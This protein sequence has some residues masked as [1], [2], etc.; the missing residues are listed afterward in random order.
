[1]VT[2]SFALCYVSFNHMRRI[3]YYKKYNML[4]TLSKYYVL[5]PFVIHVI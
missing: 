5:L 3:V 4:F 2:L 1:M